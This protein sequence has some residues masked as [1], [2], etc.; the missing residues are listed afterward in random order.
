MSN[1]APVSVPDEADY[2]AATIDS[3]RAEVAKWKSL[4]RINERRWKE[5]AEALRVLVL[6]MRNTDNT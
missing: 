2:A 5:S 1:A 3:L 4:S 6:A